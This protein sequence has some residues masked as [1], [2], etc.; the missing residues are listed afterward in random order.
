[1][2]IPGTRHDEG[3]FEDTILAFLGNILK[4]AIMISKKA[5]KFQQ[6]AYI[7]QDVCPE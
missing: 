7:G 6:T 1:M 3:C 4:L 5:P 2:E